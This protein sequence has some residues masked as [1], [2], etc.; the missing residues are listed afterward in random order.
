MKNAILLLLF[1]LPSILPAKQKV[2]GYYDMD[3][4]IQLVPRFKNVKD[5]L[6]S[7]KEFLGSQREKLVNEMN[8][9][10]HDAE[11]DSSKWS[12]IIRSLKL[13]E[14]V[15]MKINLQHFDVEYAKEL[16]NIDMCFTRQITDPIQSII[17][18][19]CLQKNYPVVYENNQ[20]NYTTKDWPSKCITQEIA[21]MALVKTD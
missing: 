5:S 11:Q 14:I 9:K 20:P 13:S 1:F 18:A 7:V 12:P 21:G 2:V 16:K 3:S 10:V 8:M 19:L 4:I 17:S 15:D 6:E